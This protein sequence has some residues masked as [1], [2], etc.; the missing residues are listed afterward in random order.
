MTSCPLKASYIK[1]GVKK[2]IEAVK[3][4]TLRHAGCLV[5]KRY[6]LSQKHIKQNR[7][8]LKKDEKK[9]VFMYNSEYFKRPATHLTTVMVIIYIKDMAT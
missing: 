8:R 1:T 6:T 3:R 9:I 7:K 2:K 5:V 4:Y